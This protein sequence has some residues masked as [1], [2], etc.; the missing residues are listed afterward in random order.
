[1]HVHPT[2]RV[3][4]HEH[5]LK[6][7]ISKLCILCMCR[8]SKQCVSHHVEDMYSR[9]AMLFLHTVY[10]IY[11][12]LCIYIIWIDIIIYIYIYNINSSIATAHFKEKG[13]VKPFEFG[14]DSVPVVLVLSP[15]SVF[16]QGHSL[17]ELV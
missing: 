13:V 10:I 15:V 8:F 14:S 11:I 5:Q 2:W 12:I 7:I 4:N 1:M 3:Y 6:V 17:T 16:N 9:I